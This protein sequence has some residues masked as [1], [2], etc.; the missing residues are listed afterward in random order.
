MFAD[1]ASRLTTNTGGSYN[2]GFEISSGALT[3]DQTAGAGANASATYANVISGA[4][5]LVVDA[6]GGRSITL[7][8]A[9]T[10]IGT[11][12]VQSGTLNIRN[13]TA[14]GT[15]AGATTVS[16]GATLQVQN[17]ITI[18]A[19]ALSLSGAGTGGNGA[20]QNVSGT[21]IFGGTI[22]LAADA[23]IQSDAGML[24]LN[25]ANAVTGGYN[26]AIGGAGNTTVAGTITIGANTLTKDGAGTLTLSGANSYTG[27]TTVS[28]GTLL[29]TNSVA[30][31]VITV[32]AAGTLGGSGSVARDGSILID[33]TLSGSS[34][35]GPINTVGTLSTGALTLSAT[36]RF[37]EDI[38]SKSNADLVD[39]RGSVTIQAG[40]TLELDLDQAA[41]TAA[42]QRG[43]S[44][45]LVR[46]DGVD[47][48][49]G[50][51]TNLSINGGTST[52]IAGD[53][54]IL[55]NGRT[56]Q[57]SYTADTDLGGT[58]ND[59]TLTDVTPA[60]SYSIAVVTS[61]G[62]G[63]EGT[64]A[65]AT[66]AGSTFTYTVTRA[67]DLNTGSTVAVTL[68]GTA[69]TR[70][71]AGADYTTTLPADGLLTFA[72]GAATATFTVTT[73]PDST[74]E[75]AETVRASLGTPSDAGSVT[76]QTATATI[77][78]DDPLPT[79]T[80]G[81]AS[82]M[83]GNAGTTALT[84]TVNLSN[85]SY[86]DVAFDYATSNG[87]ATAGSDYTA[88]AG[89]LIISAGQV[90]GTITV[91]INGDTNPETSETLQLTLSNFSNAANTGILSA[92]G[93]ILD[94]DTNGNTGAAT[95]RITD[96]NGTAIGGNLGNDVILLSGASSNN[97]ISGGQGDDR[98][99]LS[100]TGSGNVI[101]GNMG[102]D[103][104]DGT[105]TAS[106]FTAYG[107]QGDDLLVGGEGNDTFSGNLGNDSLDGGSGTDLIYGNAGDDVVSG[108]AGQDTVF[109]G[110][111]NDTLNYAAD[112][113]AVLLSGNLGND[114]VMGGSGP[115]TLLGGEGSDTIAGGAGSDLIYGN[116]GADSIVA[117]GSGGATT[118]GQDTVFGGQGDDTV[119]YSRNTNGSIIYG[120]L[121]NDSL[122]G[123]SGADVLYG[124]QGNDVLVGGDGTDTLVG[125]LG[126]D[127]LTGGANGDLF[128]I[129]PGSSGN[130]ASMADRI[131]D[132]V[133][134]LDRL[135]L[136]QQG[137]DR[138]FV[139]VTLS[140]VTDFASAQ[141]AAN[142]L[143]SGNAYTYITS[144]VAGS[145][146]YLFI[147]DN[148]DGR[149]DA[150]VVLQG[151]GSSTPALTASS[152]I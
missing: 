124:G 50:T 36:S 52:A 44:F 73:A 87:S 53:N 96:T 57:L 118:L 150:A 27:A 106:A 65:P 47:A 20:L 119:D 39:V 149:A 102:N 90:G 63:T 151:N 35:S 132:F 78:N 60:P 97:T 138:N 19:E 129:S 139:S 101:Y 88:T 26:L 121:G 115:D 126:A 74:R 116:Q 61:S 86:Q 55:I 41:F 54:R 89:R 120:N 13:A 72:A 5:S 16:S 113:S 24:T 22:T 92:T 135:D 4:G 64:P 141:A 146:G 14:L 147:D 148:G 32:A 69:T 82:L 9:N 137:T 99:G 131:A 100:Q 94:D 2:G 17:G 8:G 84:F 136:F 75:Q 15:T 33:G 1:G 91:S 140:T 125:G 71:L 43:D 42:S 133:V 59:I 81:D 111:G 56:Y 114:S 105:S 103:R 80:V 25:A 21:N 79:I 28:G 128:V 45:T 34:S 48:V 37:R 110:Q 83:E 93:T 68:D 46:N 51:F 62:T 3:L 130:A 29:V 123:G 122:L 95:T 38:A 98:I 112:G 117:A 49:S 127:T 144:G 18:G 108:S 12:N 23:R 76:N 142:S 134:G 31:S 143:L 40:A 152:I 107:G 109:G 145:D 7:S 67:G 11:T 77:A 10:Y 104:I 6:D 66:A 70:G 85:P 58:G 30:S